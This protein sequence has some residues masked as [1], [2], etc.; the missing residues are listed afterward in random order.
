[1]TKSGTISAEAVNNAKSAA[2]AVVVYYLFFLLLPICQ[3]LHDNA[4]S[5]TIVEKKYIR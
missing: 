3:W 1:M 5:V 4:V 2:V